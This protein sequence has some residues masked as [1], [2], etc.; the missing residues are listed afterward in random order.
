MFLRYVEYLK[1]ITLL[2]DSKT[3][4]FNREKPS[5]GLGTISLAL[6]IFGLKVTLRKDVSLWD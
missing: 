3:L 1:P 4:F 5:D 6:F 2:A